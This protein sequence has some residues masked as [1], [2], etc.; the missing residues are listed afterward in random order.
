MSRLSQISMPEA[1]KEQEEAAD[2]VR[3]A[4]GSDKEEE[5]KKKKKPKKEEDSGYS[6]WEDPLSDKISKSLDKAQK[7]K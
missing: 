5:A 1:S 3:N 7:D 6:W 2:S 4:F